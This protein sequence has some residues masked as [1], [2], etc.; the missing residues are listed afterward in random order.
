MIDEKEQGQQ[1]ILFEELESNEK[2][3]PITT[4]QVFVDNEA[5][6]EALEDE[7]I[8]HSELDALASKPS[9]FWRI[10]AALFTVILGYE[11]I[12]FLVEGFSDSPIITGIYAMFFAFIAVAASGY[13]LKEYRALRLLKKR[14]KLKQQAELVFMEEKSLDARAMCR[15]IVAQLPCDHESGESYRWQDESYNDLSDK[16]VLTLFSKNVLDVVD[17]KA[18][19][20]VSKHA[21]ETALLVAL[22]PVAVID[23]LIVLWRNIKLINDIAVLY[24]IKIS[25]WSRIKLIKQTVKNMLFAGASELITDV[26]TDLVGADMLGKLSGRLAQGVTAGMLTARLGLLAIQTARPLPFHDDKPR[27]KQVRQRVITKIKQ[28]VLKRGDKAK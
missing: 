15:E 23:M 18:L 24:G 16:E 14:N 22:S 28:I 11:L 13:T 1:Q 10:T 5:W 12:D 3:L 6:D 20:K 21:S 19:D 27:L 2:D 4:E 9:W 25:Y 26:S 7:A 17:Q 8:E